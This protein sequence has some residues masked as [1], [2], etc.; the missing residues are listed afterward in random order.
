M[1]SGLKDLSKLRLLPGLY[2]CRTE[3][4][5]ILETVQDM[6]NRDITEKLYFP[7]FCGDK[8]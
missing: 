6:R 8:D 2:V 5:H 4:G 1:V 7:F 3:T